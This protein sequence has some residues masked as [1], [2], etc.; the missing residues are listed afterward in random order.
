MRMR[1]MVR[2]HIHIPVMCQIAPDTVDMIGMVLRVVILNQK[3]RPFDGIVV[4]LAT[5]LGT[6]PGEGQLVF[7]ASYLW[8]PNPGSSGNR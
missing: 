6:S 3:R 1:I 7:R 8:S 2:Q 4:P 5:L